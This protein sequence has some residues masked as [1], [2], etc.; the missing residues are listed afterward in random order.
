LSRRKEGIRNLSIMGI[1]LSGLAI[2]VPAVLIGVCQT[3]TMICHTVMKPLLIVLGSMTMVCSIG[4]LAI[5]IKVR[6]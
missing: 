5:S 4:A 6:D 2:A 3:P 1:I